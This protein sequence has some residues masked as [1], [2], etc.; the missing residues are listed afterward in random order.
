M[1]L[2]DVQ[3]PIS[4]LSHY[5]HQTGPLK[6]EWLEATTV[7]L[8]CAESAACLGSL[9]AMVHEEVAHGLGRFE[10]LVVGVEE[11]RDRI[12]RLME[13]CGGRA[14]ALFPSL[15]QVRKERGPFTLGSFSRNS[16]HQAAADLACLV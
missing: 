4:L 6:P 16:A 3:L 9:Y 7:A 14:Y 10:P 1:P 15:V 11:W 12:K 5:L 2:D 8:D 13:K